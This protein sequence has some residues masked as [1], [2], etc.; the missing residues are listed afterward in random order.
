MLRDE[1]DIGNL[2]MMKKEKMRVNLMLTRAK[3]EMIFE[4]IRI[5]LNYIY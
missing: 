5:F 3:R 2:M 1:R 4:F